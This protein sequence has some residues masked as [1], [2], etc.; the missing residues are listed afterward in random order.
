MPLG[1]MKSIGPEL[2][3][4]VCVFPSPCTLVDVWVCLFYGGIEHGFYACRFLLGID[5]ELTNMLMNYSSIAMD[6]IGDSC[7]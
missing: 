4:L 5:D 1:A 6:Q 7:S 3:G 2:D